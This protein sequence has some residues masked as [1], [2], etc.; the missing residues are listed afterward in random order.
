[1]GKDDG[2]NGQLERY[3]VPEISE[4]LDNLALDMINK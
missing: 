3:E 1:M 2:K 4:A